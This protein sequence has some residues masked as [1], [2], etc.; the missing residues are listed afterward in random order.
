MKKSIVSFTKKFA[1]LF[2][3]KF[4]AI[5]TKKNF[6]IKKNFITKKIF[7]TINKKFKFEFKLIVLKS[8]T[9]RKNLLIILITQA[10]NKNFKN[11]R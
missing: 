6:A 11:E 10:S 7:T 4:V 8:N 3:K 1:V 2:I 5:L 9:K